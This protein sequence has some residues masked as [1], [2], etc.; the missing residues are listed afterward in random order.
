MPRVVFVLALLTVGASSAAAAAPEEP[1]A[2]ALAQRGTFKL[3]ANVLPSERGAEMKGIWLDA[4]Q[5]CLRKRTLRV[6]VHIDL[7]DAAA[8]TTRVRRARSGGVDTCAEG[9]PNFGFDLVPRRIG[10]GCA[11]GR[12]SRAATR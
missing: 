4:T 2:C 10:L 9:G 11:K 3:V 1:V 5:G 7:V 12:W 8:K 6:A